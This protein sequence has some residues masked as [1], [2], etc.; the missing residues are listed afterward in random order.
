[1]NHE[2]DQEGVAGTTEPVNK[3]Q[4]LREEA[5]DVIE[6]LKNNLNETMLKGDLIDGLVEKS[7]E[8]EAAAKLFDHTSDKMARSYWWK[9]VKLVVVI[10]VVVLIILLIIILL[11]T[12]IIPVS[13]PVP[14]IVESTTTP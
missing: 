2:Q 7:K 6:I 4:F 12:G 3:M 14:P 9:N 10:V 1:M 5:N 8:M 11:A 13:A